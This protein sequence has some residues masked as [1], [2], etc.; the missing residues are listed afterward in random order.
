[1][2]IS[3]VVLHY[4]TL[5]DTEN[6]IESLQKYQ[7]ENSNINIIV[8]DNG[9]Q[10]GKLKL[11][12]NKYTDEHIYFIYSEHNLGFAKGNNLGYLFAKNQLYS[13]TI[14]LC[15]NDIVFKQPNFVELLEGRLIEQP[16]DVGGPRI[17]SLADGKNQNPVP[18]LYSTEKL[19]KKRITKYQVLSIL[20]VFGLDN[21]ARRIFAKN[22]EEIK[23]W[24]CS[25]YQLHGA[26]LIFGK[27]YIEMFDGLYDGTFMY[28][29]EGILKYIA[30][31]NNLKMEYIDSLEVWHKEGSS[32]EKIYGS[33][34][35]KRLFYYKWNIDGCKQLLKMMM[36]DLEISVKNR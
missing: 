34:K 33:G 11:I 20:G 28:M 14:I 12:S 21:L 22:V 32:T 6:C 10:K 7:K 4:E 8:V 16:F 3:F 24:K 17:V 36:D 1:M 30:Q 25:D 2:I 31:K 29:E 13:D 26:C 27:K 15:N 9:S 5:D 19:I 18:Y 35:N 23:D